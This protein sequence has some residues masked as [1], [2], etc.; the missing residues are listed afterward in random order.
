MGNIESAVTHAAVRV[1]GAVAGA[2]QI[3]I[4]DMSPGMKARLEELAK[5]RAKG[6]F[7][8]NDQIRL[9]EIELEL[10]RIKELTKRKQ[11]GTIQPAE[12]EELDAWNAD[13]YET[14]KSKQP[15][16]SVDPDQPRF[17]FPE[18]APNQVFN[19]HVRPVDHIAARL[20]PVDDKKNNIGSSLAHDLGM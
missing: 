6:T 4:Q 16:G 10:E 17:L 15:K 5:I 2:K 18:H 8:V 13:T 9:S 19:L 11:D 20:R 3:S 1:V 7:T 14:W 12:Q